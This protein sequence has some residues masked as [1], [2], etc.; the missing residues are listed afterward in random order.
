M[1]LKYAKAL[2]MLRKLWN[3]IASP[4]TRKSLNKKCKCAKE[5]KETNLNAVIFLSLEM[6]AAARL[7]GTWLKE[8]WIMLL[9]TVRSVL[10][11]DTFFS[12]YLS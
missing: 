2:T 7:F 1:I 11:Q 3:I 6:R 5:T 9:L 12:Q 10:G 8:T 4:L